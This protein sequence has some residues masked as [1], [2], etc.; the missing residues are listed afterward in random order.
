MDGEVFNP[1]NS[2]GGQ[3]RAGAMDLLLC[4]RNSLEIRKRLRRGNVETG[5]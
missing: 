2:G 5:R 4:M 3:V 1:Y